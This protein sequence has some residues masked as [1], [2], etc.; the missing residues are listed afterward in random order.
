MPT[1]NIY[2][3]NLGAGGREHCILRDSL[4]QMVEGANFIH[5][6]IFSAVP[7]AKPHSEFIFYTD[8]LPTSACNEETS[9]RYKKYDYAHQIQARCSRTF[10][11]SAA[12]W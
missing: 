1:S 3:F 7:T 9:T 4:C 2:Y 5:L 10:Q 11:V 6:H 8:M 12:K